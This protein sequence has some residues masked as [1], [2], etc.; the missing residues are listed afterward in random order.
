MIDIAIHTT[1]TSCGYSVPIYQYVKE[2]SILSDWAT[3]ME[4]PPS[5]NNAGKKYNLDVPTEDLFMGKGVNGRPPHTWIE[6]YWVWAN[7]LS[8]DGL[9][10]LKVSQ[11]LASEAEKA[12]LLRQRQIKDSLE[13]PTEYAGPF[14]PSVPSAPVAAAVAGTAAAGSDATRLMLAF[15]L[16]CALTAALLLGPKVVGVYDTSV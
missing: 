16:G 6:A 9:P 1:S 15:T 3:R 14:R 8:I 7:A 2:R 12:K 11:S 13:P 5:E 4:C 10:G